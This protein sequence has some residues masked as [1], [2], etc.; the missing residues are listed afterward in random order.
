MQIKSSKMTTQARELLDDLVWET[1]LGTKLAR[2]TISIIE[3]KVLS[4]I[5]RGLVI[6]ELERWATEQKNIHKA[7]ADKIQSILVKMGEMET[8]GVVKLH[9]HHNNISNNY[10]IVASVIYCSFIS[11]LR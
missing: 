4:I 6:R 5:L 10:G 3:S 11:S 8:E 1:K 2:E 7:K 9:K